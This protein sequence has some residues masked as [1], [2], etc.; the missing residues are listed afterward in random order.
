M[1]SK[2]IFGVIQAS[3]HY[4]FLNVFKLFG[5]RNQCAQLPHPRLE[6]LRRLPHQ[7]RAGEVRQ[8]TRPPGTGIRRPALHRQ[9]S[10]TTAETFMHVS[11]RVDEWICAPQS[12]SAARIRLRHGPTLELLQGGS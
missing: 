7:G 12:R 3:G 11:T 9:N 2:K 10:R 5:P 4:S 1:S 8:R 6:H